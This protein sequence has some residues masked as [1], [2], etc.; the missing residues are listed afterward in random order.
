VMRRAPGGVSPFNARQDETASASP[1]LH[2]GDSGTIPE[3][4]DP[5][6]T[7]E[8]RLSF[9]GVSPLAKPLAGSGVT[10][11]E[12]AINLANCI[13]GAGALSL[14][15]FFK[16]TGAVLGVALLLAS[17]AWTWFSAVMMVKAADAVSVRVLD[18]VP[19]SSYEELMDLTLG[20]NGKRLSA[21]GIL[22]LQ[23]GCLVGYANILADVASPFAISV[24]PPG[25]EP[26]RGAVLAAVTFGAMLPIGV[27]VGGDGGSAGLAAVSKASIV[28]VGAFALLLSATGLAKTAE[29]ASSRSAGGSDVDALNMVRSEGILSVLPLAIFAFGAHPA[30]LPVTR[31]MRP[32]GLKPSVSVV[33]DVLRLCAAG[34]LM[35]GLGGYASFRAGTAGNVLRNMDGSGSLASLGGFGSKALKFGYGI[36]ILASVP[37][38]LLPLQKSARDAY[39]ALLPYVVPPAPLQTTAL[40]GANENE[41]VNV[42]HADL[43][44]RGETRDD[45]AAVSPEIASRL[46]T[47]VAVA[48]MTCA[49]YLSLYVPNVAFAFGLTGSTCSFLIAFV[50]PA[51][52]FLSATAAGARRLPGAARE[53]SLELARRD[54]S[55]RGA[56]ARTADEAGDKAEEAFAAAAASGAS[57]SARGESSLMR[58]SASREGSDKGGASSW[59]WFGGEDPDSDDALRHDD[60]FDGGFVRLDALFDDGRNGSSSSTPSRGGSNGA[61]VSPKTKSKSSSSSSKLASTRRWR[62]GAKAQILAAIVLSVVCTREVVRELT[63]ENALVTV[64]SKMAEAKASAQKMEKESVTI[65][66]A[67][68]TFVENAVQLERASKDAERALDEVH[69]ADAGSAEDIDVIANTLEERL[70]EAIGGRADETKSDDTK[71]AHDGGVSL[72]TTLA[73]T[74]AVENAEEGSRTET[75]AFVSASDPS[76]LKT[77]LRSAADEETIGKRESSPTGE[78][79]RSE[80]DGASDEA[81]KTASVAEASLEKVR[82]VEAAASDATAAKSAL[83]NAIKHSDDEVRKV[84]DRTGGEKAET[85]GKA[86]DEERK[87]PE[88]EGL[89]SEQIA[90]DAEA[91]R[92][93]VFSSASR[94]DRDEGD[95]GDGGASSSRSRSKDSPEASVSAHLTAA[96]ASDVVAMADEKIH[97]LN[98]AKAKVETEAEQA[99]ETAVTA[100]GVDETLAS[101]LA[102]ALANLTGS[103]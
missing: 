74:R 102:S 47:V 31:A 88:E 76:F 27:A 86:V 58:R 85:S 26:N 55:R 92:E 38:I 66:A 53:R 9:D 59:A 32:S 81:A 94:R 34:Y 43:T 24:L 11:R 16:S 37:T 1:R 84:R 71:S 80:S 8:T 17:C 57:V 46:A 98:D 41:N 50:L 64:V 52:S 39:L 93:V 15:S 100:E 6:S 79:S 103:E 89:D 23:I 45:L 99:L 18:G 7:E 77:T 62:L 54:A 61:P 78:D 20:R 29:L 63:H 75:K 30:I 12:A 48:S 91:R 51:A 73:T 72:A 82:K 5:G 56:R 60:G 49:L 10:P 65:A 40:G 68:E 44:H 13:M 22:L 36:V 21:V 95:E 33:T 101:E 69:H 35:I 90:A 97:E 67:K 70:S 3:K 96:N 4:R 25:L 2:S 83:E 14:P 87:E 19:V 42:S 28:I